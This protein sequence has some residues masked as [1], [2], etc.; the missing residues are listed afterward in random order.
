M[1]P[2]NRTSQVMH[3][4]IRIEKELILSI[5]GG[6]LLMLVL[7]FMI[8]SSITIRSVLFALLLAITSS[9]LISYH[10]TN[11]QARKLFLAEQRSISQTGD[12]DQKEQIKPQIQSVL[13]VLNMI[14]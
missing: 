5:L 13:P 11:R 4:R 6:H 9:A 1:K 10:I 3:K 7:L 8:S 14:V 2:G 12:I